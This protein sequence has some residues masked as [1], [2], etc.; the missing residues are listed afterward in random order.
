MS[1]NLDDY[2]FA[3]NVSAVN[4]IKNHNGDYFC[5]YMYFS[6]KQTIHRLIVKWERWINKIVIFCTL[7]RVMRV[8]LFLLK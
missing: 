7:S 5:L 2:L 1:G 3:F 4:T 6:L 8:K